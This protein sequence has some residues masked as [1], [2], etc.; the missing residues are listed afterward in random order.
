M[1]PTPIDGVPGEPGGAAAPPASATAPADPAAA[2]A[3]RRVLLIDV[4]RALV[5][6]LAAWLAGEGV[7]LVQPGDA[8]FEP[9]ARVELAI[10][11]V[12]FPRQ[13]GVDCIRRFASR[14]PGV[15]ILALSSTFFSGIDC[16]GPLARALGVACVLPNPVA[17]EVLVGAVRRVLQRTSPCHGAD[18]DN[19]DDRAH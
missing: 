10:V 2:P 3:A 11:D 8:G 5:D 19:A 17:R 1:P 7:A 4:D 9:G 15:P 18:H 16:H 6:L 14:Y 13:G 12:P